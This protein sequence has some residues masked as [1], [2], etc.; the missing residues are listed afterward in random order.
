MAGATELLGATHHDD[1]D[2]T[3]RRSASTRSPSPCSGGRA[4]SAS[5][6]RR[7]C[8][9]R[10][11]PAPSAMQIQ[12]G[13]PAELVGVLQATILFFLVVEPG[14]QADLP[15]EGREDR[16]RGLDDDVHGDL[17]RGGDDP[18]MDQFLYGI[19]VLGL[20]FEFVGYLI[21]DPAG[22]RADHH[23]GGGADR[24]RGPVRRHVRTVGRRQHRHRGDDAGRRVRRLDGGRLPGR[25]CSAPTRCR[26]S[27]P[28]RA[29]H[30]AGRSRS[31]PASSSR[32]ST[33]GYRSR[34]RPTR[35]SAARSSTSPR[36]GSPA[37]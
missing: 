2:A 17:R 15:A 5:C 6:S 36:S 10:C 1:D 20:V 21:A 37:T 23:A 22:H 13:V 4:R 16:P 33:P 24:L 9:A 25:R 29:P 8:S 32:S 28:R 34:S 26:S 35:S 11:A 12:A 19:P 30:R 27:V 31:C 14:H 3:G 7:C 18:L